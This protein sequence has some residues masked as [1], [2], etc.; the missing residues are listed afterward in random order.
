MPITQ[1][2]Y[3]IVFE[4][5]DIDKAIRFLINYPYDVDVDFL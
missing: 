2:L 4:G 1:M 5:Y 3:N